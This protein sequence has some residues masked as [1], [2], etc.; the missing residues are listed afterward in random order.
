M[1]WHVTSNRTARSTAFGRQHD[2]GAGIALIPRSA[3]NVTNT[4]D[5]NEKRL[6]HRDKF[7]AIFIPIPRACTDRNKFL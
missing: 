7:A 2:V 1:A 4:P 3:E 6:T 5:V